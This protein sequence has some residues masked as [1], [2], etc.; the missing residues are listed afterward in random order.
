MAQLEFFGKGPPAQRHS[1]TSVAAADAVAGLAGRLRRE[2]YEHL[3]AQG[4][5]GATD[6]ELSLALGMS[7]NTARPRRV[8]LWRAGLVE[9]SGKVRKTRSGRNATVWIAKGEV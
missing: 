3:A 6:E 1:P 4:E 8:E 7:G 5:R 9:D 2:L